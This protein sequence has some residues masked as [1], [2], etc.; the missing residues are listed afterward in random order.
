L[1]NYSLEYK[2]PGTGV[3]GA[4]TVINPMLVWNNVTRSL[5][6]EFHTDNRFS[7][8]D[9]NIHE[10]RLVGTLNGGVSS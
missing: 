6:I 1:I 10:M 4:T 5:S 8:L 9:S 3:W 2:D 7:P